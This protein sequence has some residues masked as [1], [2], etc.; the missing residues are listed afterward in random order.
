MVRVWRVLSQ[1]REGKGVV[2]GEEGGGYF[3][4]RYD[5]T[6]WHEIW[7]LWRSAVQEA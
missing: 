7:I 4:G 3:G 2:G 1:G 5:M 6:W